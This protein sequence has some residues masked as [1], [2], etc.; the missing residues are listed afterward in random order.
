[1]YRRMAMVLGYVGLFL[2]VPF[3]VRLGRHSSQPLGDGILLVLPD[4]SGDI[5]RA[6]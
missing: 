6:R 4:T 5:A 2:V 1:M 3:Y